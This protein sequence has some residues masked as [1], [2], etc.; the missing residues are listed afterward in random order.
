MKRGKEKRKRRRKRKRGKGGR[1]KGCLWSKT[2][3]VQNSFHWK[4][5]KVENVYM[6]KRKVFFLIGLYIRGVVRRSVRRSSQ[7]YLGRSR[8]DDNM[9]NCILA[10]L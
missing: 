9:S 3:A 6:C 5:E 4:K 2:I 8:F 1:G 10:S 7:K